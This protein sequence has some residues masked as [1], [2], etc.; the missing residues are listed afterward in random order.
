MAGCVFLMLL[1]L[2]MAPSH[3]SDGLLGHDFSREFRPD[4]DPGFY[5]LRENWTSQNSAP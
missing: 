1:P 5:R 4:K 3:R 2:S